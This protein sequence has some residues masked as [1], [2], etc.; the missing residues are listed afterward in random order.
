MLVI[1]GGMYAVGFVAASV[2]EFCSWRRDVE[3]VMKLPSGK[4]LFNSPRE[5][6]FIAERLTKRV[7]YPVTRLRAS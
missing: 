4:P 3:A 6:V 7:G 1:D 2:G 5:I